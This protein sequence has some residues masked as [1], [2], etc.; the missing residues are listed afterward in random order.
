MMLQ[1]AVKQG[2]IQDYCYYFQ[3]RP[4]KADSLWPFRDAR[5]RGGAG[6][7]VAF[8]PSLCPE[9][10]TRRVWQA[11][12]AAL[13]P[14]CET[15]SGLP[16]RRGKVLLTAFANGVKPSRCV[17]SVRFSSIAGGKKRFPAR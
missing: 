1:I 13:R 8:I 5:A 6:A 4:R 17:C 2:E 9:G 14:G 11:G 7:T 12:R 15:A 16:A 10:R 3:F